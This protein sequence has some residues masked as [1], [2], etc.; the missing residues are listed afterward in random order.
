E[1][2]DAEQLFAVLRAIEQ[3]EGHVA[4]VVDLRQPRRHLVRELAHRSEEA[5]SDVLRREVADEALQQRLVGG[6]DRPDIQTLATMLDLTFE[7]DRIRPDGEA[8]GP[9]VSRL[10]LAHDDT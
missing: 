1:P 5:Q 10:G 7:L 4:V 8:P 2:A 6:P 3:Q 9:L